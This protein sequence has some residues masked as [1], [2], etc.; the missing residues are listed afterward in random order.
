VKI[1]KTSAKS[2]VLVLVLTFILTIVFDLV[3]AIEAGLIVA[4]AAYLI[5]KF[6]KA[7]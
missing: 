5:K 2:D 7:K 6:K 3:V 1:V 4:G